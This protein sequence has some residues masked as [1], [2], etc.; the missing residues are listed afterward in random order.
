MCTL[1]REDFSGV[2]MG[3]HQEDLIKRLD[4][5]LEQLD[6]GLEYLQRH[7]SSIDENDIRL[8]KWQYKELKRVLLEVDKKAVNVFLCTSPG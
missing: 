4:H 2:G 6:Q 3:C 1:I 8:K 5:I 7:K